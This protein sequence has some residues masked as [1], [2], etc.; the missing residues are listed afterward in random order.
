V[1]ACPEG[2]GVTTY[3]KGVG[4]GFRWPIPFRYACDLLDL[5]AVGRSKVDTANEQSRPLV[6]SGC[7]SGRIASGWSATGGPGLARIIHINDERPTSATYRGFWSGHLA[8]YS[9]AG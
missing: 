9:S 5:P 4:P 3:T 1:V 8:C 2:I 7:Q 6:E